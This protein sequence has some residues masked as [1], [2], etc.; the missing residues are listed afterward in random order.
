MKEK[1]EVVVTKPN[2][3]KEKLLCPTNYALRERGYK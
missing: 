2:L 1:Q 3:K